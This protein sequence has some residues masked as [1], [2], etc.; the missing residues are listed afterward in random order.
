[1]LQNYDRFEADVVISG[2]VVVDATPPACS[3]YAGGIPALF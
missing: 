3:A 2:V 1:M